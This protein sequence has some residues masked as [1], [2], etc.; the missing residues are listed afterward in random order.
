MRTDKQ[1]YFPAGIYHVT[2]VTH[3]SRVSQR[4]IDYHIK[5]EM[6]ILLDEK[7]EMKIT[8]IIA[9]I[10]REKN[11]TVYTYNICRDHVHMLIGIAPHIS[12]S[13]A[14]QYLKGKSSHK[15]LSE[16]ARLRK[17]YWGQHLWAR[18]YWVATSGNVTDEVW[19]RYIEEQKPPEPDDDFKVV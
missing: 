11:Y 17:R 12:V 6:G 5:K 2:W 7:S 16:Y 1:T 9:G 4:M 10:V 13:R 15:L 14:V 18:G 8:E 3:N 19:K